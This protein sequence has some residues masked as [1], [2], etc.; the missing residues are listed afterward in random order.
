MNVKL[1][2]RISQSS[3]IETKEIFGILVSNPSTEFCQKQILKCR[4]ILEKR[5][6]KNFTFMMSNFFFYQDNLNECKLGNFPEI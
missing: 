2:Q 1:M 3:K 6:L 4:N 5:K